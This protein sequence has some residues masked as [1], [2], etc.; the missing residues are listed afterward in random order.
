[1]EYQ[2]QTGTLILELYYFLK[3]VKVFKNMGDF[4]EFVFP[5]Y[6]EYSISKTS[7]D[8]IEKKIPQLSRSENQKRYSA[9]DFKQVCT[10]Y[11][12]NEDEK[13]VDYIDDEKGEVIYLRTTWKNFRKE[14]I[15]EGLVKC[16]NN[17][18][19]G[20]L[21]RNL[22][23]NLRNTKIHDAKLC[24]SLMMVIE[25]LK[26]NA[27][28]DIE[29]RRKWEKKWVDA[30]Y[31]YIFFAVTDKLNS[32]IA[33]SMYPNLENDL[34]EYNERVTLMYGT[35]GKPGIYQTYAL[36]NRENPNIIALYECGEMEYYGT[37][38]T[39]EVN[40]QEAYRYYSKTRKYNPD[41]PLAT[42]S[43]AYMKFHYTRLGKDGD[44]R[45]RNLK[46]SSGVV[47]RTRNGMKA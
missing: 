22:I 9:D 28:R 36:A 13:A 2:R 38:P 26:E 4:L 40:Y 21:K 35:S 43:I 37:G 31:Y 10:S 42:W 23:E 7:K 24:N 34:R 44:K 17:N 1:M 15:Y 25:R 29:M 32:D 46:I 41:H 47:K 18:V 12:L 33:M 45:Y 8:K 6:L 20:F 27:P 14:K 11:I 16:W 39:R 19:L 30:L 3:S 5:H